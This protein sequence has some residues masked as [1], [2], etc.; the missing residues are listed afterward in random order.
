MTSQTVEVSSDGQGTEHT[1]YIEMPA[2]GRF[3]ITLKA[4]DAITDVSIIAV[5][6]DSQLPPIDVP[7]EPIDNG[8][9]E[10]SCE[11]E[12]INIFTET[13]LNSDG[14]IDERELS[15]QGEIDNVAFS[16]IDLNE[17]GEIE[18]RE[19]LQ[20]MCSCSSE[21]VLLSSQ[22][23]NDGVGMSMEAFKELGLKNTYDLI[24]MDTNK[25]KFVTAEEIAIGAIICTTTFDAFDADGDG[26]NDEDDAFPDDPNEAVDTDGDG[27]GDNADLAPGVANDLIYGSIG[28][29]GS[30]VF[31]VLLLVGLGFTRSGS[32]PLEGN[33]WEDLKQQDLASQML[34][35]EAPLEQ[36]PQPVQG[37]EPAIMYAPQATMIEPSG[38]EATLGGQAAASPGMEVFEDLLQPLQGQIEAPSQQL[39]GMLDA[40]GSEVL[41][42]PAGSGNQ[43]TRSSP[44]EPWHQR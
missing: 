36:D 44:T 27:V 22:M 11:E 3:D 4:I 35:L 18:Y 29:I 1:L 30:V 15:N 31:V 41:E 40:A 10:V 14:V 23:P 26:V 12:A 37:V 20:S 13:D 38:F 24:T 28:V 21:L 6:E 16:E 2:N 19:A 9:I 39:M 34:G 25:D 7:E 33:D 8:P 5:W 42:Y 17:D 43:W 32:D